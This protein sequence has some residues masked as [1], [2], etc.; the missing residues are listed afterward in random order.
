M[1]KEGYFPS[2]KLR[3]TLCRLVVLL[4]TSVFC[5]VVGAQQVAIPDF[6]LEQAIWS[7]LNKAP[8]STITE[9]D[10]LSL[11]NLTA[12]GVMRLDG[13]GEAHNLDSLNLSNCHLGN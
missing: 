6:M 1:E 4:F 9:Q 13:L 7:A 10:M 5:G 8:F 11:T 3:S 2:P 12:N